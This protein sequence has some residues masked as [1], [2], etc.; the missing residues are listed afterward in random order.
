MDSYEQIYER[1]KSKYIAV[2]DCD[3]DDASEIAVKFRVLAGEIYNAQVNMEWLKNQM[4]IATASGESLDYL[5]SQRGL[6]RKSATKAVGKITFYLPSEVSHA[7]SIPAGSVVATMEENPVRFVTVEDGFIEAGDVLAIV[8]AQAVEAGKKGN[9]KADAVE[10]C[11]SV[12]T[13]IDSITNYQPFSGGTDEESDEEL[14]NR[15]KD[16][17]VRLA[18]GTNASFYEQLAMTIDGVKKASAVGKARGVGTVNVYVSGMGSG[19]TDSA[20]LEIQELMDESRELNVDVKVMNASELPYDLDVTVWKKDGYSSNEVIELCTKAFG[21]YIDS[22]KIGSKLYLSSLGKVL[23]DTGCIENYEF[24]T[25]M[26]STSASQS[27]YFT[28]GE[29]DIEVL[30]E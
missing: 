16:S 8:N 18:N 6:I 3:F 29:I 27:Q 19:V 28:V 4:F 23:L 9:I 21:D 24:N 26:S 13:E 12:P 2:T 15:I 30:D 17:Y 14:R 22:I 11:V 10:V 5:A 7:V 1:M 20:L 25:T